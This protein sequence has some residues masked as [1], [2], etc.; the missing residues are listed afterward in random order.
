MTYFLSHLDFFFWLA[1]GMMLTA[2]L[3]YIVGKL[4]MAASGLTKEEID[5]L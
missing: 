3:M 4:L 2:L 5:R 1:I